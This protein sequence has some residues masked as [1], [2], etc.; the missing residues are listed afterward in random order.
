[1]HNS[2]C[3]PVNI[4]RAMYISRLTEFLVNLVSIILASKLPLV[5]W[6]PLHALDV[7][8]SVGVKNFVGHEISERHCP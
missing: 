3:G 8:D 2:V 6:W 4:T 7:N 1:V 5:V